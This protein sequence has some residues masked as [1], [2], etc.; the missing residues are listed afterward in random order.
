MYPPFENSKT[1]TTIG[2]TE[3]GLLLQER[4]DFQ[5][6]D[7]SSCQ[8]L[9][10]RFFRQKFGIFFSFGFGI[11]FQCRSWCTHKIALAFFR[12]SVLC[13]FF[14]HHKTSTA[15]LRNKKHKCKARTGRTGGRYKNLEGPVVIKV[16][17]RM[18][19]LIIILISISI[20]SSLTFFSHEQPLLL[21]STN[22]HSLPAFFHSWTFFWAS[23]T[24][25]QP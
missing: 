21:F 16:N 1:R 13:S 8:C 22:E 15:L 3:A 12:S 20:P 19:L 25:E 18:N 4:R 14:A 7:C 23:F 24:H 2:F 9:L 17:F 11:W 6:S 10:L 5:R